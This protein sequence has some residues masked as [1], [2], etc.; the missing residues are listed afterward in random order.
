MSKGHLYV[1]IVVLAGLLA[2]EIW[3]NNRLAEFNDLMSLT[4]NDYYAEIQKTQKLLD[5]CNKKGK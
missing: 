5:N 3:A 2:S 4:A 1:I